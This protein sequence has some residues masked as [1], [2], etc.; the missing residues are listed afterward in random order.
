M[1]PAR[2]DDARRILASETGGAT[3]PEQVA[4]GMMTA[5]D[6]FYAT[7]APLIGETGVSALMNRSQALVAGSFIWLGT[8]PPGA[9][10][11]PWLQL[12]SR[13]GQQSSDVAT[14]ASVALLASFMGLLGKFIGEG[15]TDVLVHA[16]WP[17]VFAGPPK[18]TP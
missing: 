3:A 7:L 8:A 11:R 9:R 6:R 5:C 15:L 13:I 10:E 14:R 16:A 4:A 2:N 17:E 1:S 12:R 18:E